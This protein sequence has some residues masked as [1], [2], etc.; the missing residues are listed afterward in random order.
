M[1]KR[2]ERN[3]LKATKELAELESSLT[4]T[5]KSMSPPTDVMKRLQE[6]IGNLEPNRI[7]KRIGSWELSIITIGTVVSATMVA[8]TIARALFYFFSKGK[9]SIA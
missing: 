5:L 2:I 6:R 9:R 8:L 3:F 7:A 4:D 1:N